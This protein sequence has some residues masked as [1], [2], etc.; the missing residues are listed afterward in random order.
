MQVLCHHSCLFRSLCLRLIEQELFIA[1]KLCSR[2]LKM[3][4][5]VSEAFDQAAEALQW[6]FGSESTAD[7]GDGPGKMDGEDIVDLI[8]F[9]KLAFCFARETINIV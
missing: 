5:R 9:L 8:G 7:S 2:P 6:L 4:L 3:D 1:S